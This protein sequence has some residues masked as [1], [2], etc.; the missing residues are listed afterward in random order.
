MS[1]EIVSKNHQ[2]HYNLWRQLI[3]I[4]VEI[5]A[6]C[7]VSVVYAEPYEETCDHELHAVYEVKF[8]ETFSQG[9]VLVDI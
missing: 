5:F 4:H 9:E 8:E 3:V 7:F 1:V 2:E 6:G